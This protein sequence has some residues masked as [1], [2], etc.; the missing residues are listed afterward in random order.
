MNLVI[1]GQRLRTW[2][3][4]ALLL[5]YFFVFGNWIILFT[6]PDE[7]RNASAVLNMVK[8]WD[9]LVP[10]YNCE[11]RIEKPPMLYW[12]AF[13]SSQVLC[14]NE[15]SLRLMSGLSAVG[16]LL[17]FYQLVKKHLNE[18]LARKSFLI[19]LTFPHLWVEGRSFVPEMLNTFFMVFALYS[20]LS[21]RYAVGW[22]ILALAFLTKGPVG[23]FLTIAVYI[24]WKRDLKFV[25]LKA[26][27]LFLILGSSWYL[28]MLYHFGYQYFF[29]FFLYENLMRFTGEMKHHVYPFYYYIVIIILT[30]LFYLPSY[31]RL[32]KNIKFFDKELLPYLLWFVF[33]LTFYTLSKNKLHHYIIFAYPPL[34]LILAKY[35]SEKY[36]KYVL[37]VSLFLLSFFMIYLYSYEK[38]RFTPHAISI[39]K[40]YNGSV[41]FYKG[42]DSAIVFYTERCIPIF[43][44]PDKLP[45]GLVIT[46]KEHTDEIPHCQPL[47][48][49][50]DFERTYALLECYGK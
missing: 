28:Y 23:V 43:H 44:D 27:F 11:P 35:T 37:T 31:I 46:K 20:F 5:F 50:K 45:P 22:L 29:K 10:Y 36:I 21:E 34:A 33:V 6:S 38:E 30:T 4:I 32:I 9:L 8:T 14:L 39:V 15:F 2:A 18:D 16:L 40:S 41:S 13:L 49:A 3:K 47:L 19:L 26:I 42:E 7:G 12:V 17:S 25:N 1:D 24:L 48:V